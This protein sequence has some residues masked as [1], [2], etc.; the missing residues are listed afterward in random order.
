MP[1]KIPT[2]K[3]SAVLLDALKRLHEEGCPIGEDLPGT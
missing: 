2:E 3:Q 1:R